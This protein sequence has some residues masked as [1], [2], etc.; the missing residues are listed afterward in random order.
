VAGLAVNMVIELFGENNAR[1]GGS[2]AGNMTSS[3]SKFIPGGKSSGGQLA[4]RN[5]DTRFRESKGRDHFVPILR[6]CQRQ[7]ADLFA[8]SDKSA[9]GAVDCFAL[10]EGTAMSTPFVVHAPFLGGAAATKDVPA[11]MQ[12]DYLELLRAYK[13]SF[14]FWLQ[15]KGTG[16]SADATPASLFAR[17]LLSV[18]TGADVSDIY[19]VPLSSA[20]LSTDSLELRFL[21]WLAKP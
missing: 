5:A 16:P 19:G 11:N 8:K 10:T 9:R 21:K 18:K 13:G 20:D 4:R 7:G 3:Q 6:A 17:F 15:T 2:G 14:A 1:A 12:N